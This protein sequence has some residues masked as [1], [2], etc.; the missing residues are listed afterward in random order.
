MAKHGKSH[1]A[2]KRWRDQ[3]DTARLRHNLAEAATPAKPTIP[4]THSVINSRSAEP[5][6]G[7][8]PQDFGWRPR[9]PDARHRGLSDALS[10][11]AACA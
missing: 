6:R 7:Y 2:W 10:Y 9:R 5:Q 11:M 1:D 8:D 4:V 3:L